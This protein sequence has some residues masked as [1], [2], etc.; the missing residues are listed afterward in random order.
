M[1]HIST[2]AQ[3]FA[4]YDNAVKNKTSVRF[5]RLTRSISVDETIKEIK[6]LHALRNSASK[7]EKKLKTTTF[8]PIH[9]ENT[10]SV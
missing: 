2:V 7:K 8:K 4:D 9:E 5:R 6:E 3:S 10:I 1:Q